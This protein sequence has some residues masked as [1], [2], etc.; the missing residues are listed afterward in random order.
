LAAALGAPVAALADRMPPPSAPYAPTWSGVYAGSQ[1]GDTWGDTGWTFAFLETFNTEHGRQSCGFAHFGADEGNLSPEHD[2][3]ELAIDAGPPKRGPDGLVA[4][5]CP[6]ADLRAQA[7]AAGISAAAS[8]R[9]DGWTARA[10]W[11]WRIGRSL[12]FGFEYDYVDFTATRFGGE[13]EVTGPFHVDLGDVRMQM[14]VACLS[15]LLD[16]GPTASASMKREK[17]CVAGNITPARVCVG[18]ETQWRR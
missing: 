16:R 18:A 14:V 2:A 6:G 3:A 15:I 9:E 5:C 4:K 10:G 8:Q 17:L 12:V 11:E 1:A 7:P 13:T